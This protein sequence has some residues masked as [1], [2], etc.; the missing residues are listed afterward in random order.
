MRMAPLI[1]E[2]LHAQLRRL[3]LC[4]MCVLSPSLSL[5]ALA[6]ESNLRNLPIA[7]FEEADQHAPHW[8]VHFDLP[9]VTYSQR[10]VVRETVMSGS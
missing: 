1:E 6:Q 3:T 5:Q 7:W 4:L 2:P 9:T 8:R 10:L